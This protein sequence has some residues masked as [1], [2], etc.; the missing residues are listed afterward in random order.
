MAFTDRSDRLS[1]APKALSGDGTM[2]SLLVFAR[3]SVDMELDKHLKSL[4]GTLTLFSALS[5][6]SRIRVITIIYSKV[7]CPDFKFFLFCIIIT[8]CKVFAPCHSR[9]HEARKS[10]GSSCNVISC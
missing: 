7:S 5:P 4:Q 1:D 6:F 8:D 3:N 9:L 2:N 10:G